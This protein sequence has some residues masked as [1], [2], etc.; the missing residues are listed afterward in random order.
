MILCPLIV[1]G[2]LVRRAGLFW[3]ADGD[4]GRCDVFMSAETPKPHQAQPHRSVRYSAI[5][6]LKTTEGNSQLF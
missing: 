1:D 2:V 6:P 4:E 5:C 3:A